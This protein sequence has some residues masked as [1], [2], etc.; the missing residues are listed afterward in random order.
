[1]PRVR[2]TAE[3]KLP[4]DWAAKPYRQG[5]EGEMS[6]DEA[7][8]WVRRGVAEI[9]PVAEPAIAEIP[10]IIVDPHLGAVDNNGDPILELAP[11]PEPAS[12]LA[13]AK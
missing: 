7:G 1:M 13:P 10:V 5:W 6:E 2:F 11:P 4:A 3:P 8:R 9:L 12:P